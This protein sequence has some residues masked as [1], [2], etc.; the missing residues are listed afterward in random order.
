MT[1]NDDELMRYG[2]Q[3]LL[4]AFG[5]EGQLALKQATV[6]VVGLGG[7]GSPV[8]LYLAASGVGRLILADGD[9]VELSNL[10]RQVVHDSSSI[11]MNKALSAAGALNR[12]N[13]EITIDAFASYVNQDNL[14]EL[15]SSATLV[16]DCSD[17]FQVRDLLNRHC[18]EA[19]V[20]LV[21]AAAIRAEGQLVIFDFRQPGSACYRCLYPD[22]SQ[23]SESCNE[24]GVFAPLLGV[25][26]SLQAMEAIRLLANVGEPNT[27]LITYWASECRFR[28]FNLSPNPDCPICSMP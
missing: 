19:R 16:V 21:S 4:P 28:E 13:P 10:Q 8:S 25:M 15:L 18:F 5:I 6:L 23:M 9:V 24:S 22:L 27:R 17:R 20:P 11:G 12:L 3:I 1:L 2:R 26:G 7:L 14:P